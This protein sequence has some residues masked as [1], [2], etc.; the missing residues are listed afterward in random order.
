MIS[1]G[2]L[3]ACCALSI[4]LGQD[5]RLVSILIV[6][7]LVAGLSTT[8][9]LTALV[10]ALSLAAAIALGSTEVAELFST[11]HS[12]R[13]AVVAMACALAIQTAVLRE[14]DLRT[15]RR[16]VLINASRDQLEAASGIEE[17]LSSLCRA[18]VFADFAEFAILDLQLPDG[19][20]VRIVERGE[21]SQHL[22]ISA[23]DKPTAATESYQQEVQRGGPLLL[24]EAPD[25]LIEGLFTGED[26]AH[27]KHVHVIVK[28]V[29]VGELR[30]AYFFICPDPKPAW[31]EAEVTQIASLARAAAQRARSDQL[32][33][34]ITHA[35]QELRT[36]RD[37]VS[38]IV[39]GIASGIIAQQPDGEIVYANDV[40]ARMLDWDDADSMIG[41]NFSDVLDRI[42]LRDE[43]GEPFDASRVPSRRA[44]R[45][46]DHPTEL[47]RYS[48]KS[49]GEELW[50]FV[51][52]TA[53]FDE[54]GDPA[55]AI[56][57]I[58]DNTARKRNELSNTFLADASK[59]LSE[60]L[61][62]DSAVDA[63]ARAAVP[64]MADWCTIELAEPGGKIKTIAVAHGDPELEEAVKKF[65]ADFPV[66]ESDDFG[67]AR[68]IS[69]GNA[70]LYETMDMERA[71][72][73]YDDDAR[74]EAVRDL[75]PRTSMVAP[76]TVHGQPIGSIMLAMTRSGARYTQFDLDTAI[77]LG[78]RAGIALDNA[79]L[80][81]ERMRMLSSLQKSLIPAEL[82]ELD[83]MELSATFRPAERDA[84]VG[85]DFYDAFSLADGSSALV[86]GDVCG[87]GPEAAA[88]TALARYTIRA[89][90]MDETDP[91][92]ILARLNG[93]LLE[94]VTD[95]RFVTV[96]MTRLS[97]G[98][99]GLAME[100]VSAGHPLPL[101]TGNG[102][103]R[104]IGEPGTLLGVVPDPDLPM[105]RDVLLPSESLVLYTDGL[106]AGQTTDDT[107]YAL[108]LLGGL[109]LNGSQDGAQ[110]INLAAIA[111]QSEPN[112]DDV[113]ILVARAD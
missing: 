45:G 21:A 62:F 54:K 69:T 43:D 53:I 101:I 27:L 51:R 73:I 78:R 46:E 57:V 13:V 30:A 110:L 92:A 105:T 67:P 1:I 10:A 63:I 22:Q 68:A 89:A 33:D 23:R 2:L 40:A 14:R 48:I 113:A 55:L 28:Q 80:H 3:V 79:R 82:P 38:A 11:A 17:A 50:M 100:S 91:Q 32:I 93:A 96:S 66:S 15:R 111:R 35:Q 39:E 36:S 77:E 94:Q 12:L 7:P 85:G 97:R 65:R 81:T 4:A 71:R 56:A 44:L 70:D 5:V 64:A 98:A 88:L 95:G 42:V 104:P 34:R 26:L 24:R 86:I 106:S 59:L 20:Q 112:R 31:G 18:V 108:E 109:S 99:D 49:T 74:A 19:E 83:G 84:E 6:P 102:P 90:A 8:P 47:F 75:L 29:T 16:L 103:P 37:E 76:I 25:A 60:S 61:D 52:S 41:A 87:K 107:M 58:E 72:E 9:R